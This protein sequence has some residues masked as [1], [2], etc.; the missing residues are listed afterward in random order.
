MPFLF[1]IN[2]RKLSRLPLVKKCLQFWYQCKKNFYTVKGTFIAK[3]G[4]DNISDG[5]KDKIGFCS[6]Y[7]QYSP[8]SKHS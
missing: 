4:S 1:I 5:H 3:C 2:L 7:N 8:S 6:V